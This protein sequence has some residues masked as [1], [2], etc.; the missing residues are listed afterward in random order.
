MITP[1]TILTRKSVRSYDGRPIEAETL[2]KIEAFAN[3]T[4][5]P[6][7][8]PV[9]FVFL[10]AKERELSSPVL[11][12]EPLYVAGKVGKVPPWSICSSTPGRWAWAP[13]GSA[14]P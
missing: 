2:A 1:E 12:G 5:N 10:D 13:S 4:Q 14:A 8:I 6:F 3:E 7:G 9:S 11:T